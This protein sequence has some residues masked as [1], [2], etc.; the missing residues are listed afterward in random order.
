MD[1]SRQADVFG[2]EPSS[3]V[4]L[5]LAGAHVV[6]DAL[7]SDQVTAAWDEPSVLEQQSVGGLCGHL[8]RGA[9]WVVS[10]YLDAGEPT[11]PVDFEDAAHY[12]HAGVTAL[13]ADDHRAI[14]ERGAAVGAEGSQL[15]ITLAARLAALE[16]R[17]AG[18]DP[19]SLI[20]VVAGRVMRLSDYLVTRIVE[21][22]VHLDDLARSVGGGG[23]AT[24][25]GAQQLTIA[26]GAEIARLRGA[27]AMVRAL[28]RAGF[29]EAALPVL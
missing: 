15:H 9:V 16:R 10:D 25:D 20:R 21:Q 5:F 23:W 26:V 18:L 7:R 8:A 2:P 14:R 11:G 22:T 6:H 29:A 17:L 27:T 28:Y 24:P 19:D 3:V 4:G 1:A 13:S 12:F